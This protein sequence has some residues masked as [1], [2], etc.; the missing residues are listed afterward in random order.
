MSLCQLLRQTKVEKKG[1][2]GKRSPLAIKWGSS[3][4]VVLV[5]GYAIKFPSIGSWKQF[6]WGLLANM[7]E[8]AFSATGWPELCP[9]LWSLPGGLLLVMPRAR[10]LKTK[11][12]DIE[13]LHLTQHEDRMIPAE[14]KA[15]SWGYLPNGR[16]VAVDYG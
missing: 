4:M 15:C 12:S 14:N 6:L 13:Y 8:V 10:T 5:F 3:R 16:L 9:V 1:E 11:L 2:D 7:Q